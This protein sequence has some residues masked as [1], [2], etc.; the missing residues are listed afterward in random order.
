MK[1]PEASIIIPTYNRTS[2][3]GLLLA[4]LKN[5]LNKS[6]ELIIVEQGIN[7]NSEISKYFN[8]I[9]SQTTYLFLK[10]PSLTKA[11]NMGIN[12]SKADILIFLDDDVIAKKDL[13][14]NH[15]KNYKDE[16]IGGVVGRVITPGQKIELK[17]YN[18]GKINFLGSFSDG[19]SSDVMQEVDT[20]IGCNHSWRKSLLKK[21]GGFDEKFTGNAVREDSDI[22]LRIKKQNYKI[23][24]DPSIEVIHARAET[25]GSRKNENRV[26]WYFD[27]FSNET[28]FFLKHRP[29]FL[30]PLMIITKYEWFIR[31]FFGFRRGVNLKLSL[32]T[33]FNGI[34]D[35]V[36]K[37]KDI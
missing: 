8:G 35:G 26:K 7:N 19:Y 32:V 1:K 5:Q 2:S 24:F 3:I 18:V 10:S 20:V 11:R 29:K 27:F 31:S 22:S 14:N 16:L 34:L 33:P 13:I 37:Y 15:L 21:V 4:S 9:D 12:A 28:Y 6:V 25:G 36:R 23:I 30:F 17:N